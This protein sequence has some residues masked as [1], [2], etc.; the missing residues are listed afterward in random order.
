LTTLIDVRLA[1]AAAQ[2]QVLRAFR[3]YLLS[4]KPG[5]KGD[6]EDPLIRNIR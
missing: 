6:E 4:G 5:I 1:E 3:P 2:N